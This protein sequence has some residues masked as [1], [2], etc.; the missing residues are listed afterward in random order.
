[1]K[2]THT[3]GGRADERRRGLKT[4]RQNHMPLRGAH[5]VIA[6]AP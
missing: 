1:M 4:N 6:G 2:L 3:N 5:V